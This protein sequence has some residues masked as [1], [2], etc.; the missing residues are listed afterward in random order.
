MAQRG[1]GGEKPRGWTKPEVFT[2]FDQRFGPCVIMAAKILYGRPIPC[3]G[4]G[5]VNCDSEMPHCLKLSYV[6]VGEFGHVFYGHLTRDEML[7]LA[8]AVTQ[9]L[10]AGPVVRGQ[11]TDLDAMARIAVAQAQRQE[12]GQ[13]SESGLVDADGNPAVA[14]GPRIVV[15]EVEAPADVAVQSGARTPRS[16]PLPRSA[17][18]RR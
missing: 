17:R 15:P 7:I 1:K 4:E 5:R 14:S 12:A 3:P 13:A 18:R 6:F 11:I 8:S 16:S 10:M 2:F 9:M